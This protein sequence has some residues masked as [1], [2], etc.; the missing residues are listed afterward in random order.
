MNLATTQVIANYN[1]AVELEFMSMWREALEAYEKASKLASVAMKAQNPM[2]E[3]IS[4][5]IAK[6]RMKVRNNV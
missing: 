6:M 1:S 3:K 4:Q 5:A 2:A